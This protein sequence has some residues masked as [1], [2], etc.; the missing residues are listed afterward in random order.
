LDRSKSKIF[1]YPRTEGGFSAPADWLKQQYS[2]ENT[3]DM[4]LND[5]IFL[6]NNGETMK[7]FKGVAEDWKIDETYVKVIPDRIFADPE[8]TDLFVM[9]KTDNCVFKIAVSGKIIQQYCHPEIKNAQEFS[10]DL[11]HQQA[12]LSG[13]QDV[14]IFSLA[15][16]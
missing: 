14:K 1:R 13:E 12:I 6:I 16:Q 5:N 3:T 2:L 7:F 10:I 4:A 11:E 9:D 15:N 8:T